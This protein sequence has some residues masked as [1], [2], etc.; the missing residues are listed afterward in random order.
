MKKIRIKADSALHNSDRMYRI[1]G[2]SNVADEGELPDEY[3]LGFPHCWW[4]HDFASARIDIFPTPGKTDY[5]HLGATYSFEELEDKISLLKGCAERLCDITDKTNTI[6]SNEEIPTTL[7]I[8]R[9]NSQDWWD[10][11]EW[12]KAKTYVI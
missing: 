6:A 7:S 3:R 5:L 4:A 9:T 8:T 1:V 11:A 2:I 10:H 12:S